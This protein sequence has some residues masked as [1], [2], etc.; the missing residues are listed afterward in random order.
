MLGNLKF[1]NVPNKEQANGIVV[2]IA[3]IE[4][5][6]IK[7]IGEKQETKKKIVDYRNVAKIDREAILKKIRDGNIPPEARESAIIDQEISKIQPPK[8]LELVLSKS[9]Q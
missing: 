7:E 8:D 9:V 3:K 4:T 1:R 6:E 5:E 2:Q